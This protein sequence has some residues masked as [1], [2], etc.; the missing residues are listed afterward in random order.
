MLSPL[1]W[2]RFA[3][4]ITRFRPDVKNLS[5]AVPDP[6]VHVSDLTKVFKV[7]EREGGLAAALRSVFHRRW[8]QVRAVDG[9]SFDIGPG[10]VVGFLG[11]NGARP[12]SERLRVQGSLRGLSPFQEDLFS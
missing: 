8:R 3:G 6:V 4:T 10:E 7:P 1:V 5:F 2:T 12:I 9:I 11:P